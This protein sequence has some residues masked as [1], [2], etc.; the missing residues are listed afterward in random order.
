MVMTP[1]PLSYQPSSCEQHNSRHLHGCI[2]ALLLFLFSFSMLAQASEN[3]VVQPYPEFTARYDVRVNNIKVGE[4]VFSLSRLENNEYLYKQRTKSTGFAAMFLSESGKNTS[5]WRYN[6]NGI[7]VL[8]YRSKRK[9]GDADDNVHLIFDWDAM[10]VTNHKEPNWSIEVPNGALDS[11]VMQLAMLL[12]LRDGQK[13]FEF[14]VVRGDGA[15][16]IYQFATTGAATTTIMGN[17]FKTIELSRTNDSKDVSRVWSAP[18]LHYFPVR[19][20]KEKSMGIEI[21]MLLTDIQFS[22]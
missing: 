18:D 5:R 16:K 7:Q 13:Q 15:I 6:E 11:M 22:E 3:S 4:S 2:F 14:N 17:D 20:L 21:E 12:Q 1:A 19:F 10:I 8:E 9:G